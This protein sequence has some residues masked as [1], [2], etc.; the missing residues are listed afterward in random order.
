MQENSHTGNIK[1]IKLENDGRRHKNIPNIRKFLVQT[2]SYNI[3]AIMLVGVTA[4]CKR[5]DGNL[6]LI[7]HTLYCV[8]L[9][10]VRNYGLG[11][12]I[13]TASCGDT[14]ISF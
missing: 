14:I 7:L 11:C 1:H 6:N 9:N 8:L 12:N 3:S 4:N 13:W 10:S 5:Q 2:C